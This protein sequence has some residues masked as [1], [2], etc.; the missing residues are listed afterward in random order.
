MQ[1]MRAVYDH[2]V[3][4]S[5][6]QVRKLIRK[7]N[8]EKERVKMMRESLAGN[9][10]K[11]PAD[12]LAYYLK[13]L[14]ENDA[15]DV[16]Y[17][18]TIP[19]EKFCFGPAGGVSQLLFDDYLYI[20]YPAKKTA[21]EYQALAGYDS[22]MTAVL[23]M[24]KHEPVAITASGSFFNPLNLIVGDYWAWSEKIGTMLPFD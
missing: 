19:V 12:S 10:Q 5:G 17:S 9:F 15:I 11:L 4:K 3:E 6:F 23:K 22:C 18:G 8:L 7:P 16:L 1:F 13:I 20:T 14:A 24:A 21:P 2:N